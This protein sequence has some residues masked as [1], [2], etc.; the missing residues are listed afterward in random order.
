MIFNTPDYFILLASS[1]VG[2]RLTSGIWRQWVLVLAGAFFFIWF[3]VTSLGGWFGAACLGLF[4]WEAAFSRLYRPGSRWCWVG[5][6]L[7]LAILFG[8]KYY[9]FF[10]QVIFGGPGG[11]WVWRDAFLPFG[12]S[13]VRAIRFSTR[14]GKMLAQASPATSL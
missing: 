7:P 3:S 11:S 2:F 9:N 14:L 13:T 10:I 1:V 5:V 6:W 8:F 4:L 12:I